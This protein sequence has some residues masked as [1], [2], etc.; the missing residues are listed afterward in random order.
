MKKNIV[1][2]GL[3]TLGVVMIGYGSWRVAEYFL[4]IT[5]LKYVTYKKV[6]FSTP[7]KSSDDIE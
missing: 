7:P 2:W 6:E 1:K 3:V 4:G 5:R